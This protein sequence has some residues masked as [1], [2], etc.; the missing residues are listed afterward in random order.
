MILQPSHLAFIQWV[1]TK[2]I[3]PDVDPRWEQH[4]DLDLPVPGLP[5][6]PGGFTLHWTPLL[7]N[8]IFTTRTTWGVGQGFVRPFIIVTASRQL[9]V[10]P[11]DWR[12]LVEGCTGDGFA[13]SVLVELG[14]VGGI[15][16]MGSTFR[17]RRSLHLRDGT[18]GPW[19]AVYNSIRVRY[20]SALP[21]ITNESLCR[22]IPAVDRMHF[23]VSVR[24]N[25]PTT[26]RQCKDH[27]RLKPLPLP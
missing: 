25:I 22:V 21:V 23:A 14:G 17:G 16:G 26:L 3:R 4:I 7:P 11:S 1:R 12:G 8:I 2:R 27:R 15:A 9:R 20:P 18:H 13:H 19:V 24:T 10:I 6:L 5:A